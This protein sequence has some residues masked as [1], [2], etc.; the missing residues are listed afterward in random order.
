M[1]LPCRIDA[2]HILSKVIG[3]EGLIRIL[4]KTT[5][6]CL[7]EWHIQ[8]EKDT[9]EWKG[10]ITHMLLAIEQNSISHEVLFQN[11]VPL[12]CYILWVKSDDVTLCAMSLTFCIKVTCDMTTVGFYILTIDERWWY[13]TRSLIKSNFTH[14]LLILKWSM[15]GWPSIRY[16]PPFN[17]TMR[18]PSSIKKVL[19]NCWSWD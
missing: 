1:R 18:L 4:K 6:Y 15:M 13:S 17:H 12:T 11:I 16:S 19:T 10:S 9:I 2:T 7:F 14:L 5:T 8:Y 3:F